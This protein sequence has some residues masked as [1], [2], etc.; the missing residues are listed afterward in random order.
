M[1]SDLSLPLGTTR[2]CWTLWQI[3]N[4]ASSTVVECNYYKCIYLSTVLG[5]CTLLGEY[6]LLYIFLTAKVNLIHLIVFLTIL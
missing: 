6:F 4:C 2:V 5:T 1:S 3:S